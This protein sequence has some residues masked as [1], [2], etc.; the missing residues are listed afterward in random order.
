MVIDPVNIFSCLTTRESS[1]RQQ[2]VVVYLAPP[3]FRLSKL[4]FCLLDTELSQPES[5]R[6]KVSFFFFTLALH[7]GGERSQCCVSEKRKSLE[8]ALPLEILVSAK[9]VV[10][11]AADL[12]DIW[13]GCMTVANALYVFGRAERSEPAPGSQSLVCP[14]FLYYFCDLS[15][16]RSAA[17]SQA[18]CTSEVLTR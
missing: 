10:V 18:D 6:M 4:C 5:V 16:L 2:P 15:E 7:H 9:C 3:F 8:A 17:S 1:Q 13:A 12:A 11:R 14:F